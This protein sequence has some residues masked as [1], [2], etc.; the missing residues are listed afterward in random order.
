MFRR[1]F[2]SLSGVFCKL[3]T[4]PEDSSTTFRADDAVIG[5]FEHRYPVTNSDAKC[6][7]TTAFTNH[8]TDDG[9]FQAT[10]FVHVFSNDPGLTAFFSTNSR[11]STRS[12]NKANDRQPVFLCHPHFGHRFTITFRMC[13]SKVTF[14]TLFYRASFLMADNH[15]TLTVKLGK[16]GQDCSVIAEVPVSV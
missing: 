11:R 2:K 5:E 4:L 7:A 3:V 14:G 9:R 12:I 10:H 8:N 15:D 13:T 16:S 1:E 6:A